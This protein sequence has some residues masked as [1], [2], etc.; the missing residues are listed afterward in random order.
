MT[1]I[2]AVIELPTDDPEDVF[3]RTI[4]HA[5]IRELKSSIWL[6]DQRALAAQRAQQPL[7]TML[8]ARLA[9]GAQDSDLVCAAGS[10]LQLEPQGT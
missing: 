8:A 9:E 6:H 4:T 2:P 7:Q 1:T 5:T 3:V 10:C